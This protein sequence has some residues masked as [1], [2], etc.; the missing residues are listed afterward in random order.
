MDPIKYLLEKPILTDRLVRWQTFL[1]QFDIIYVTQRAVKEQAI[2]EHLAHLPLPTFS[3]ADA[4]FP[5]EE[6][7]TLFFIDTIPSWVL[8]FD[9]ALNSKGTGIGAVLLS[10]EGV[11][12]PQAIQLT[13]PATNNMAEYEALLAGLKLALVINVKELRIIGDSQLILRQV[14]AKYRTRDPK[15]KLYRKLVKAV[16]N[17]FKKLAYVHTP[18]SQNILANSLASLASSLEIPL[19]RNSETIVVRTMDSPAIY[20]P[21]F[22]KFTRVKSEDVEGEKEEVVVLDEDTEQ[23]DDGNPWYFDIE[24]YCRDKSFPDYATSDDKKTLKRIAYRYKILGGLLYK[25]AFSGLLLRCIADPEC[26]HIMSEAHASECGGHFNGRALADKI[27][28]LYYWPTLEADCMDFVRRCVKCQLHA[29]KIHTLSSSLHPIS[30][31]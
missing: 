18:R 25:K 1:S 10:P 16:V 8:Y 12:I 9:G 22:E 19:N 11:I 20:D 2:V 15:L 30:A 3:P 7:K 6:L 28:K 17:Q 21:W 29:N 13:F 27:L 23:F 14:L 5:D 31:P 24:N 4:E 26:L